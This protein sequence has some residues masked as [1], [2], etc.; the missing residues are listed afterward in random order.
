MYRADNKYPGKCAECGTFVPKYAGTV[1]KHGERHSRFVLYCRACFQVR[2]DRAD[3]SSFEDRCC[4]NSAYEDA[5]AR[6][7]GF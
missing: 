6:K 4:G 2:Y 1:E 3:N 5:C 7:C